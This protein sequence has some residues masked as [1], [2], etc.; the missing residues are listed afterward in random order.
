MNTPLG[1]KGILFD[2]DGTLTRPGLLDFPAMKRAIG[3]PADQHI[4]EFIE[5]R[6]VEMRPHLMS[7]LDRWEIEAARGSIPN[8]GAE[9]CLYTLMREGMM[10]GILTRN[11]LQSVI[12]AF[13]SFDGIGIDTFATVV[14]RETSRPKPHPEGVYQA[15]ARMGVRTWEILMVGDFRFDILAGKAAGARTVLL[16]NGLVSPLAPADPQPDF[17]IRS[18]LQLPALLGLEEEDLSRKNDALGGETVYVE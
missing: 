13:M 12:Q 7:I 9:R 11:S 10:L 6:P 3:C 18:L 16:T 2:F 5:T 17:V 4:L 15:A 1:I 8:L 14:T